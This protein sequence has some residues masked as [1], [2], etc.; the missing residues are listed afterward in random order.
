MMRP[1][2]MR[3][4]RQRLVVALALIVLS[5]A[6]RAWALQR[7]VTAKIHN[8]KEGPVTITRTTALLMETYGES[9]AQPGAA[10]GSSVR[11]AN[12]ANQQVST[13][14]LQGKAL[15]QSVSSQPIEAIALGVALLDPFH[16]RIPIPGERNGFANTLLM[17]DLPPRGSKE[18]AWEYALRSSELYEAAVTITRIRFKDGTVWSAPAEEVIDVF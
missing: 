18:V 13:F 9:N 1:A 2:K 16:E 10:K 3:R 15:C 7:T 14:V 8:Y 5:A 6:G 17:V 12:R 11:Y 4:A